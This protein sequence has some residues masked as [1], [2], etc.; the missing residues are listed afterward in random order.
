M[1]LLTRRTL[2]RFAA[3]DL[4]VLRKLDN[5]ELSLEAYNFWSIYAIII[6]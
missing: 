5:T 6:N 2:S 3:I 4:S 1:V